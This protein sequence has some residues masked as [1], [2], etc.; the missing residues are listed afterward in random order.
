M[1]NKTIQMNLEINNI[2]DIESRQD[3][4][5]L[6]EE[7]FK[8]SSDIDIS[9]SDREINKKDIISNNVCSNIKNYYQMK[10]EEKYIF[11][12][13]FLTEYKNKKEAEYYSN[14]N[15]YEI[16]QLKNKEKEI[17]KTINNLNNKKKERENLIKIKNFV[18]SDYGFLKNEYREKFYK[19]IFLIENKNLKIDKF[20]KTIN[21]LYKNKSDDKKCYKKVTNLFKKKIVNAPLSMSNSKPQKINSKISSIKQINSFKEKYYYI[22]EKYK[23]IKYDKII[24]ADVNRSIFNSI[25]HENEIDKIMLSYLKEKIIEKL[26]KFFSLD[27]KFKYYQGFHDISIFIYILILNYEQDFNKDINEIEEDDDILFYEILQ[28]FSEFYLKDYLIEIETEEINEKSEHKLKNVF[29]YENIYSIINEIYKNI[30]KNIYNLIQNK[31]DYAEPIYTLPWA[32]TCFTHE[33]RNLNIIYRLFDYI[34]F[35][36]P[37]SIFYLAANVCYN[38][39][40][41]KIIFNYRLL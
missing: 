16:E 33:I 30:D 4:Q 13:K 29:N 40:A 27:E 39:F 32:L 38:E 14:L 25:F 35:Q 24:E 3:I 34:L 11:F 22:F 8:L 18:S 1:S 6:K 7:K 9:N 17:I 5:N 15:K 41:F 36:H 31:S 23:P 20:K 26:K 2:I 28:R 12:K 37:A 10:P 19:F 21:L